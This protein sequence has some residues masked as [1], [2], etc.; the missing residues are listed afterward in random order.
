MSE[1]ELQA[2]VVICF[3]Y[4]LGPTSQ[5]MNLFVSGSFSIHSPSLWISKED[6]VCA[7]LI[8]GAKQESSD[9]P[10]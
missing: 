6:K 2:S 1:L 4:G 5:W 3:L 7:Y 9:V 10:S 8:P